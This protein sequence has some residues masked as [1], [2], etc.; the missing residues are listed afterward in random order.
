MGIKEIVEEM[1]RRKD[2]FYTNPDFPPMDGWFRCLHIEPY[3][4]MNEVMCRGR[5]L[6]RPEMYEDVCGRHE[7]GFGVCP[8]WKELRRPKRCAQTVDG[9]PLP[10]P[11]I[12]PRPIP[13]VIQ[14][15][16]LEDMLKPP[17][18]CIVDIYE[19]ESYPPKPE[20]QPIKTVFNA[21]QTERKMHRLPREVPS[22]QCKVPIPVSVQGRKIR[23]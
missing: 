18:G 6:K 7:P 13:T 12:V 9:K 17:P 23:R 14:D 3:P 21:P 5:A 2:N 19:D 16:E 20:P 10:K 1:R 11:I 8:K 4:V 15:S 22:T